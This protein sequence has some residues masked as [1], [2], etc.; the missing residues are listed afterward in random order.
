MYQPGLLDNDLA[1]CLYI[2]IKV[3]KIATFCYITLLLTFQTYPKSKN[4]ARNDF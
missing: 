4:N 2:F 3:Y 1:I